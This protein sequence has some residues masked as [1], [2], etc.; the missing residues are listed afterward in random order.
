MCEFVQRR[1]T[2]PLDLPRERELVVVVPAMQSQVNLSRI[3]RAAGCFGVRHILAGAPAR[4]DPKIARAALDY[5]RLDVHRSL[6][7]VV[8]RFKAQG[9]RIVGLEQATGSHSLF[10]YAFSRHTALLVGHE[11]LGVSEEL[12]SLADDV[13]EIPLYGVPHSLNAATAAAIAIYEYCRQ[14]PT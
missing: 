7:P 8:R 4:L 5:V 6:A 9:Y 3:V 1:H 11:R 14:F 2:P 13:V 12:L 10:Q